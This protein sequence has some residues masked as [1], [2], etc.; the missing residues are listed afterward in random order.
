MKLLNNYIIVKLKIHN[1]VEDKFDVGQ[2]LMLV[3]ANGQYSMLS[4]LEDSNCDNLVV[5]HRSY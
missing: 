5:G 4:L 2:P 3:F 1:I